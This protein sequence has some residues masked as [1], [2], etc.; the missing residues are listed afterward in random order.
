MGAKTRGDEVVK[1]PKGFSNHLWPPKR[2]NFQNF[3]YIFFKNLQNFSTY[4]FLNF[5]ENINILAIFRLTTSSSKIPPRGPPL[6]KKKEK[7]GLQLYKKNLDAWKFFYDIWPPHTPW[8]EKIWAPMDI[9]LLAHFTRF[10]GASTIRLLFWG[11][12]LFMRFATSV[13]H[14]LNKQKEGITLSEWIVFGTGVILEARFF[15]TFTK[16]LLKVFAIFSREVTLT[17]FSS[18][19]FFILDL[20]QR[21]WPIISFRI[22]HVSLDWFWA[23]KSFCL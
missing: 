16:Y 20:L 15:P 21:F 11:F 23:S 18:V 10:V 3:S 19:I 8:A 9:T 13:G 2:V 6:K 1:P 14:V 12:K 22:L 17:P 4:F 5:F 7:K